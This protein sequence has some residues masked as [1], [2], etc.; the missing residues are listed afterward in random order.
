MEDSTST[1]DIIKGISQVVANSFDGAKNKDGEPL[2]TGLKRDIEVPF[3]D[4]RVNDGFTVKISGNKLRL[5]YSSDIR[6]SDVHDKKFKDDIHQ[7]ISDVVAFIKRE[8]KVVTGSSLSLKE[9]GEPKIEMMNTSRTRTW[10]E[11]SCTYEIG[12]I[13][14]P[15]D[16]KDPVK[17]T[18]DQ[19]IKDWISLG[20][21]DKK[22]PNDD[23]KD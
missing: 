19:A 15:Q 13:K 1:Y 2:K 17:K 4:K 8:Y 9:I 16:E 6:I 3:S 23:R 7:T 18:Y 20:R 12:G 22:A 21:K 10:V 11:A 5:N 14:N